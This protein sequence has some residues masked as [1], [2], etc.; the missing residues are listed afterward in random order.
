MK[1]KVS[2]VTLN[3]PADCTGSLKSLGGSMSDTFN[4]VLVHQ[5][6]KSLWLKDSSPEGRKKQQN[7]ILTALAA[8]KPENEIEGM[9]SGLAVLS[10]NAA[11]ECFRRATLGRQSLEQRRLHMDQADRHSDR[12]LALLGA[13]AQRRAAA[14]I[15]L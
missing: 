1:P 10:H 14:E 6:A 7:A 8:F 4:D 5:V 13:L 9:L 15:G 2:L 11:M 12:F 3:D